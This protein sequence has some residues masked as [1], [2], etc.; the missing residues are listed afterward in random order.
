MSTKDCT[1]T[2]FAPQAEEIVP[3]G[4]LDPNE[5]H[6]P[7]IYVDRI[8]R[9]TN[10]KNIEIRTAAQPNAGAPG[11]SSTGG[12]DAKQSAGDAMRHR[13]ARRA[14]KEINDG[15]YVNLG[16]GMP[17]LVPEHLAPGV[18][19]WLQSENGI[20][21]MGPYPEESK[22][23]AYVMRRMRQVAW[24]KPVYAGISSM[25]GRRQ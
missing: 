9:A 12:G 10:E 8:V 1:L 11:A 18:K 3:V 24:L 17:T 16:I 4:T 20:L 5:V 7:G 25:P 14:A 15:D 2:L 6:L 19:V 23:D 13:I 22:I 21:G